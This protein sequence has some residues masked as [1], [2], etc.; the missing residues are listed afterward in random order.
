MSVNFLLKRASAARRNHQSGPPYSSNQGSFAAAHRAQS[1]LGGLPRGAGTH[2]EQFVARFDAGL[3]LRHKG[4][5]LADDQVMTL[6]LG[7]RSSSTVTL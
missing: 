1:A 2:D 5:T 7:S 3:G 4:F 6:G